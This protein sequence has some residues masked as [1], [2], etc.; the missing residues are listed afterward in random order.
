MKKM[1]KHTH[2]KAAKFPIPASATFSNKPF[3]VPRGQT[4]SSQSK[5]RK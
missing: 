5:K 3:E 2:R 1:V 4:H